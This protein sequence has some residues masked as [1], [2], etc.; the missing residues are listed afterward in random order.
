VRNLSLDVNAGNV[1]AFARLMVPQ[2]LL[3]ALF[4]LNLMS[5]PLPYVGAIKPM[6]VMMAVYYWAINRPTL[7]PPVLCFVMGLLMDI[8][9]GMPPGLNAFLLVAV[10]WLV[11]DQRRFLMGQPFITLWALFGLVALGAALLQWMLFG[12]V[13]G[14]APLLPV[15]TTVGLSLFLF[16]F[17]T[18]LLVGSHRLLPA[19]ARASYP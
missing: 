15:A 2:L 16:P 18:L 17:V 5:L 6:L 7:V 14:W 11:R 12:I 3:C 4:L 19:P 8:L 9:S 1:I 10:Q 13:Q